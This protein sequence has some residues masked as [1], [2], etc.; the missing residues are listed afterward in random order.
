M[1]DGEEVALVEDIGMGSASVI[2]VESKEGAEGGNVVAGF[3]GG[4]EDEG[5]QGIKEE[6][7]D[8]EGILDVAVGESHILV[9]TT[10]GQVYAVG[11][12]KWGQLGTGRRKFE[13]EWVEVLV[14]V[15]VGG[16][17]RDG[18]TLSVDVVDDVDDLVRVEETAQSAGRHASEEK[19][20]GNFPGAADRKHQIRRKIVGVECGFWSSFLLVS[21]VVG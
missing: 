12:G 15:P 10:R 17:G 2:D 3:E 19:A 13:N 4:G 21:S 16:T 6:E 11:E 14:Q 8:E 9:L 7:D 20:T 1:R 18:G 5:K